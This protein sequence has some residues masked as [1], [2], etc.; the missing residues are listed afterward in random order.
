MFLPS[1]NLY[2]KGDGC[3]YHLVGGVLGE[4]K[5]AVGIRRGQRIFLAVITGEVFMVTIFKISLEGCKEGKENIPQAL[6]AKVQGP[7]RDYLFGGSPQ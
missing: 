5:H 6:L 3:I 4:L 7:E 1:R 2:K